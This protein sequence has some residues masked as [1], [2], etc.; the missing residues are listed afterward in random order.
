MG[1]SRGE[2]NRWSCIRRTLGSTWDGGARWARSGPIGGWG[3]VHPSS[4]QQ[5]NRPGWSR[6]LAHAPRARPAPPHPGI[7]RSRHF[8]GRSLALA[9]AILQR[10]P[11]RARAA[12]GPAWPAG[13]GRGGQ[14]PPA[15]TRSGLRQARAA[16][17]AE[18]HPE[19]A[20]APP[21]P[22]GVPPPPHYGRTGRTTGRPPP[23]ARGA[24]AAG[25]LTTESGRSL[26]LAGGQRSTTTRAS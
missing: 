2:H 9:A 12:A 10:R 14:S 23:R 21:P 20:P 11:P 24:G 22:R 15:A 6:P 19:P 3:G 4:H 7:R 17:G 26:T 8:A 13:V 16:G 5:L 18:L 25:A 1:R